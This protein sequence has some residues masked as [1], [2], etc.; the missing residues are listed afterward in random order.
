[1]RNPP[2]S[3]EDS[4][5]LRKVQKGGGRCVSD[6]DCGGDINHV[7]LTA[8]YQMSTEGQGTDEPIGRG[9]CV[10]SNSMNAM[11]SMGSLTSKVCKC[12]PGFTGPHCLAQ[13]HT[14]ESIS[15]YATKMHQVV[16]RS[17]PNFQLT[18]FMML[19]IIVLVLQLIGI[20][21]LAVANKKRGV[22]G[23]PDGIGQGLQRPAFHVTMENKDLIITGR[24]V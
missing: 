18:P 4:D 21:M 23:E 6:A 15:A 22:G 17:I 20:L 5:P 11:F 7:N 14:D 24:S 16:F 13:A 8:V 2:F 9:K 12:N 10:D 19:I 3:Y 1:M